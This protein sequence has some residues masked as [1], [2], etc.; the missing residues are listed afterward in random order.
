MPVFDAERHSSTMSTQPGD[1]PAKNRPSC[2]I[3]R[4]EK[5][6]AS[7]HCSFESAMILF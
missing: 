2:F 4:I 7:V 5:V 6:A 1:N 3:R